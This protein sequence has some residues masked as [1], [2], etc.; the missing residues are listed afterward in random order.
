GGGLAVN[1]NG[2]APLALANRFLA[3]RGTQLSGILEASGSVSGSL[4]DPAIRAM[5]STSGAE[6]VDPEANLRVRDIN[7]MGTIDGDTVILRSANAAL[8]AGGT[9]AASG[10]VSLD[11]AAGFPADLRVALNQA[12]YADG[13]MVV[14]TVNGN[15]A[16][17]GALT[18]DPLITGDVTVERAEITVPDSFGGGAAMI[19]VIHL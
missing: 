2:S 12:R 18:R 19:D 13:D 15:L 16:M 9:V 1:F 7:I 6:V 17:N 3:E 8:A 11:A 14:A 4:S 5:F 10:T